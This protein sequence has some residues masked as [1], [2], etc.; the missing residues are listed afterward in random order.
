MTDCDG[1]RDT[2]RMFRVMAPS[3]FVH[4]RADIRTIIGDPTGN[5]NI[6]ALP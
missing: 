4:Y 2:I 1:R 6:G 3:E 5:D